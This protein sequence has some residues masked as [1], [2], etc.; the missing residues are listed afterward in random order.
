MR[1]IKINR[2]PR[3]PLQATVHSVVLCDAETGVAYTYRQLSDSRRTWHN[4]CKLL[5]FLARVTFK[6]QFQN[7]YTVIIDVVF[8]LSGRS[9]C[10]YQSCR[11]W[12]YRSCE[13]ATPWT[14]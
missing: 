1:T 14:H 2:V 8:I 4:V 9:R 5:P 10:T 11:K 6:L 13:E 12:R 7:M 3:E